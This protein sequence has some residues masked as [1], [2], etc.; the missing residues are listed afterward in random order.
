MTFDDI[1]NIQK[2]ERSSGFVGS[3]RERLKAA[4][5]PFVVAG[6]VAAMG[7]YDLVKQPAANAAEYQGTMQVASLFKSREQRFKEREKYLLDKL[8]KIRAEVRDEDQ[9]E[10]YKTMEIYMAA[11]I[12]NASSEIVADNYRLK[13]KQISN[14]ANEKTLFFYQYNIEDIGNKKR[15]EY[16]EIPKIC[17]ARGERWCEP[18]AG[19]YVCIIDSS[20]RKVSVIDGVTVPKADENIGIMR[21]PVK[22]MNNCI[23]GEIINRNIM[24]YENAMKYVYKFFEG[25]ISKEELDTVA[26][27][28]IEKGKNDRT[29]LDLRINAGNTDKSRNEQ[30]KMFMESEKARYFP[31]IKIEKKFNGRNYIFKY[32]NSLGYIIIDFPLN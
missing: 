16:I 25:E 30:K 7:M 13:N 10:F 28:L 24:V 23:G 8:T 2:D 27:E 11:S 26:T 17:A 19:L 15:G 14:D 3:M 31:N 5:V 1:K 20:I 12:Q 21:I 6:A 32:D 9:G 4:K 18:T 22:Y 29:A